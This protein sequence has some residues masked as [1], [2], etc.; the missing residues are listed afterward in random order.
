[1]SDRLACRNRFR[2]IRERPGFESL[3]VTPVAD[4]LVVYRVA[5]AAVSPNHAGDPARDEVLE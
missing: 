4:L 5:S 2:F 1:V 3:G